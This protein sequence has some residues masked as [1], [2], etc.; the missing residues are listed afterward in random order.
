MHLIIKEQFTRLRDGDRLHFESVNSDIYDLRSEIENTT[1]AEIILRNTEIENLQCNVFYA[2]QDLDQ[3][4]CTHLNKEINS[5]NNPVDPNSEVPISLI[6]TLLFVVI[7]V[8]IAMLRVTRTE[9]SL[10][11]NSDQEE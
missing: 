1:L 8:L 5:N 10:N 11:T 6:L 7:V 3:M 4:D 2:E 9:N